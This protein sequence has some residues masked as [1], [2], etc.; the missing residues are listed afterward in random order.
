MFTGPLTWVS[1]RISCLTI[2]ADLASI[3]SSDENQFLSNLSDQRVWIGLN[4]F[5]PVPAQENSY[6]WSDSTPVSFETH[7]RELPGGEQDV[8]AMDGARANEGN[9]TY[10]LC[11]DSLPYICEKGNLIIYLLYVNYLLLCCCCI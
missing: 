6:V 4:K 9:W 8:I 10:T 5:V 11:N 3:S 7:I 2:Q 1:A